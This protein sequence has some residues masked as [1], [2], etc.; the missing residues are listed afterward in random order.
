MEVL[1]Q[2]QPDSSKTL[3]L[4]QYRFHYTNQNNILVMVMCN[5]EVHQNLA[6]AFL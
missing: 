6:F 1:K 5:T 3:E 4:E 2:V